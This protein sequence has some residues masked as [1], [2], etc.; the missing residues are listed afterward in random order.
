MK[1]G[2][3]RI[4]AFTI[5]LGAIIG[6]GAFM[7]PGTM[8]LHE[9]GVINSAI[10]ITLGTLAIIIIEK[11]YLVMITESKEVGGEFSYT[12]NNLGKKH[13]FVVGWF[14][15]LA[16]LA[17][18][19]LNATAFPLVIK[20]IFNE[21]LEVGYLYNVA[22]YNVYF[23]EVMVSS[24]IILL[25]AYLNIKGIKK[26][27]KIQ[28]VIVFGLIASVLIT[29]VGMLL[30]SDFTLF[31][32]NYI[33]KY[34]FKFSE[35]FKLFAIAPWA[36]IGFD[37]IAQLADEFNF[38]AKKTSAV[39]ILSLVFGALVYNI[40][41]FI[42]AIV[43]SPEEAIKSDWATGMAVYDTLGTPFFIILVIALGGAVWSGINGFFLCTSKLISSLANYKIIPEKLGREN[44]VGVNKNAI[45]FITLVSLVAPWFGRIA[46][47]WIVD[48]S[49][50][51]AAIAYF[52]VSYIALKKSESTKSKIYAIG[53]SL[54]SILF[55][56]LLI[57]PTSPAVLGKEPI[58]ALVIWI[59]IGVIYYK[60]NSKEF[61]S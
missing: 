39:A 25:F 6:W 44:N 53:G 4:D 35:V 34:E 7:L 40:L 60:N 19:P 8:F 14:L 59:I 26:S 54:I 28:N 45:I 57:F 46:L 20:K 23:G 21:L 24:V 5:I 51:G 18:I 1:R 52:Y 31:N 47:T 42:T 41:N 38:S 13:G 49:S 10:G 27:S 55:V 9:A 15:T 32:N 22:G 50:L 12:Y 37:A 56:L 16:Y 2:L 30:K 3:N 58:I 36:F 61:R 43:Y 11:N 33:A 29:F 17:I 48:M